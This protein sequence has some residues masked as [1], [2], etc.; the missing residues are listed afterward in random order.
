MSQSRKTIIILLITCCLVFLVALVYWWYNI[1]PTISSDDI[2]IKAI[3]IETDKLNAS[4]D[5]KWVLE[6]ELINKQGKKLNDSILGYFHIVYPYIEGYQNSFWNFPD[7]NEKQFGI[8][9]DSRANKLV[10]LKLEQTIPGFNKEQVER[11][12]GYYYLGQNNSKIRFYLTP[13]AN[14]QKI[15]FQRSSVFYTHYEVKLGKDVSWVKAFPIE[16]KK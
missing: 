15:N 5:N 14:N 12:R 2:D 4:K 9:N 13:W 11:D 16:L 10:S 3:L 8:A 1:S 7:D 6:I